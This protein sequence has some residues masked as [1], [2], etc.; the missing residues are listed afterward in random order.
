[1]LIFIVFVFT[2]IKL[3]EN[4]IVLWC[5]MPSTDG[6]SDDWSDQQIHCCTGSHA[7]HMQGLLAGQL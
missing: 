1:L 7:T 6:D 3:P 2:K 4:N 5:R